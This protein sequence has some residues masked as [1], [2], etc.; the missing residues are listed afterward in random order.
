MG[1]IPVFGLQNLDIGMYY[2]NICQVP[3]GGSSFPQSTAEHHFTPSG[4]DTVLCCTTDSVS[5]FFF[6]R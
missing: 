4:E 3:V 6:I 2:W 5:V 1:N